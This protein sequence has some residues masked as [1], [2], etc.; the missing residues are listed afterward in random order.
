[1]VRGLRFSAAPGNSSGVHLFDA[2]AF[3]MLV[4]NVCQCFEP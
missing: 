1:M 4:L 3:V 2:A